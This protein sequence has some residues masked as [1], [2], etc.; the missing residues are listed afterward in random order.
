MG[1]K[2]VLAPRNSAEAVALGVSACFLAV[3]GVVVQGNAS[4]ERSTTTQDLAA[5][6]QDIRTVSRPSPKSANL[7]SRVPSL[8][9]SDPPLVLLPVKDQAKAKVDAI[10]TLREDDVVLVAWNRG[11]GTLSPGGGLTGLASPVPPK[12]SATNPSSIV[13]FPSTT[14]PGVVTAAP[15]TS[16]SQPTSGP[17]QG[18]PTGTPSTPETSTP[19]T[20]SPTD[21]PT[22]EPTEPVE[23][24]PADG[25]GDGGG[26]TGGDTGGS[27]DG[28]GGSTDGTNGGGS[29]TDSSDSSEQD[30]TNALVPADGTVAPGPAP[31]ALTD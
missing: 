31:E 30:S 15:T 8:I 11:S 24:T 3:A 14:E 5:Q 10:G 16:P 25:G 13:T 6:V 21:P 28:T 1:K 17:I 2:V 20:E 22:E 29:G 23:T 7:G 4:A 26:D 12:T 19:P 18:T 9:P 27:T